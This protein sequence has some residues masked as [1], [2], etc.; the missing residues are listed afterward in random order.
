[1]IRCE[2]KSR[3]FCTELLTQ[4]ATCHG[5]VM[6]N[7]AYKGNKNCAEELARL[8]ACVFDRRDANPIE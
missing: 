8:K 5:S 2:A 4:Y 6:S 3:A 1:L 7:G